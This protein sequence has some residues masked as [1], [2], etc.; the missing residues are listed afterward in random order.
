MSVLSLTHSTCFQ[1]SKGVLCKSTSQICSMSCYVRAGEWVIL[2][3]TLIKPPPPPKK[4]KEKK[5]KRKIMDSFGHKTQGAQAL[6]FEW[7]HLDLPTPGDST[8]TVLARKHWSGHQALG[9][10]RRSTATAYFL[11]D[12]GLRSWHSHHIACRRSIMF[13]GR[14]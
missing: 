7:V 12:T 8:P 4:K 10:S 9:A 3:F 14:S 6:F 1:A 2:H 11:A 5:K 13:S